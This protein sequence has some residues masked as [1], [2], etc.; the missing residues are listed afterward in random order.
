MQNHLL[1]AL[2]ANWPFGAGFV[3]NIP[4]KWIEFT[5]WNR[6]LMEK[7]REK[8]AP[9]SMAQWNW[10][11]KRHDTLS[12]PYRCTQRNFNECQEILA[13]KSAGSSYCGNLLISAIVERTKCFAQQ[14]FIRIP[15]LS[16]LLKEF[17]CVCVVIICSLYIKN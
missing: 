12:T 4:F 7:R 14:I 17:G 10:T 2:E 13:E 16:E 15:V 5:R 8:N 9:V 3:V 1:G 11:I 6:L